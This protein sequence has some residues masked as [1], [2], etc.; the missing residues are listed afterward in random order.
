MHLNSEL[1]A[2]SVNRKPYV[3]NRSGGLPIARSPTPPKPFPEAKWQGLQNWI[4]SPDDVT[5]GNDDTAG[6]WNEGLRLVADGEV[7]VM[8]LAGGQGT[9]LGPSAPVAKGMLELTIPQPKSLFQLQA[10]RLRLVEDLASLV[11]SLSF[12]SP[13]SSVSVANVSHLKGISIFLVSPI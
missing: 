11:C 9:R 7:A 12:P 5:T 8:A 2:A 13:L 4:S 6:W 3:L 10:E 1:V